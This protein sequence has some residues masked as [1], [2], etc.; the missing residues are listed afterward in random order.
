MVK[1]ILDELRDIRLEVI[2]NDFKLES[3]LNGDA[4]NYVKKDAIKQWKKKRKII[5]K[6]LD[7]IERKIKKHKLWR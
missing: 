7:K 2:E 4:S 6:R 5:S 3:F 1:E